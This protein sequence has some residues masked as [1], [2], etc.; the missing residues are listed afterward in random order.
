MTTRQLRERT[1]AA[2]A[3]LHRELGRLEGAGLI[4]HDL[5]GR[6]KLYTAAV[7]SPLH[8]PLHDLLRKTLGVEAELRRRLAQVEG[9]RIAAIFGSW[10]EGQTTPGSDIDLLVLGDV[11]RSR[12]LATAREV[13][14]V[15]GRE[16]DV[17]AY[18]PAE[19]ADRIAEGSGFLT[20]ILRGSLIPLI[21]DLEGEW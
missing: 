7:D 1:G 2:P 18:R 6:T 11:D 9:V 4:T 19:F 8:D 15:A 17:T 20:T 14:R 21:G 10:A 3:S 16:I 13:E 12:L 5:I